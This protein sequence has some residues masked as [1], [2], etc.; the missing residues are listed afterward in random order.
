MFCFSEVVGIFWGFLKNSEA[1]WK[2]LIRAL[3]NI[4]LP[5]SASGRNFTEGIKNFWMELDRKIP[6]GKANGFS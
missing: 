3:E 4:M 6:C 2:I 1:V 5:Y